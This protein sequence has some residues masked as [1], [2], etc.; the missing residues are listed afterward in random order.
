MLTH[1]DLDALQ[2]TNSDK[3]YQFGKLRLSNEGEKE[4]LIPSSE[5]YVNVCFVGSIIIL[6]SSQ[7][8]QS[9]NVQP[10]SSRS[11]LFF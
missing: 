2:P 8:D 5:L 3:S 7:Q 10:C 6:S 4:E 1:F 11:F 9:S